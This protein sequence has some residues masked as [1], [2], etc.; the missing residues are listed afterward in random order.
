M[1]E[2]GEIDWRRSR[3]EKLLLIDDDAQLRKL[4]CRLIA[5]EY[6][7]LTVL[8][9]A[10]GK[11]GLD[12]YREHLPDIVVTDVTM[13]VLDGIAVASEIKAQRKKTK[14]ILLSANCYG[15]RLR[16][17][18]GLEITRQIMKPFN[19]EV[20]LNAIQTCLEELRDERR[21]SGS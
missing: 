17:P 18:V 9:A 14:I 15:N 16:L 7:S 4:L 3:S 21:S 2:T 12:V 1:I 6:S 10:D 8:E 20:L 13:P 5:H 19:L 11:S